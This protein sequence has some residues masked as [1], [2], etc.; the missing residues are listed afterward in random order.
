MSV[1][2]NFRFGHR[3]ERRRRAAARAGRVRDPGGAA[4]R[5]GGRDRLLQP[6]PRAAWPP[7]TSS[8][9]PRFLGAPFQVRGT[10]GQR[11][12]PR[13]RAGLPDG[14][15]G[16]RRR[17]RVSRATASTPA[18]RRT[19]APRSTSACGRPSRPVAGCWSRPT[20][21]TSTATCTARSCGSSS[22]R[23]C[24]GS[25]GSTAPRR[26][27]SAMRRD[28][29]QARE[30][31]Q[32]LCY[33]SAPMTITAER[34]REL[35]V[36]LRPGRVR[37]RPH[38]GPGRPA[39]RAHQRAH[40]APARALARPPLAPR[41]AQAGRPAPAAA[42]LP[43][44]R[45]PRSLPLAGQGPRA[46]A[47]SRAPVSV[48]PS[49]GERRPRLHAAARGRR[50]VRPRRT[51]TAQ[52]QRAGLL[53]VR[54]QPGLHRPAHRLPRD[55]RRVRGPGSDAVRRLVRLHLHAAGVP[56]LART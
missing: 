49:A 6:H 30:A 12:P 25:G 16:A 19:A 34:K 52:T 43:A 27:S 40:R 17:P 50:A 1:G 28:V 37:H 39:D 9:P 29:E 36:A 22:S 44:A 51:C 20:C 48:V 7:A 11:R 53:P 35:V 38:R 15:P 26:S 41:A 4:G 23:G 31:C 47:L 32:A 5:G 14:Q 55:A 46:A 13:P 56:R 3:A 21:S 54:L 33:G 45:R 42:A 10:V 18:A 24:A 2:E 8:A